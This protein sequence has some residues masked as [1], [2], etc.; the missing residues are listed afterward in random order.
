MLGHILGRG[1][2]I[3]SMGRILHRSTEISRDSVFVDWFAVLLVIAKRG[4]G[5]VVIA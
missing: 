2:Q 1:Q 5:P 3:F 4:F